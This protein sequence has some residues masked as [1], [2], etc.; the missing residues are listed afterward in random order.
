ME[1]GTGL[2]MGG[3]LALSTLWW[4]LTRRSA[5]LP[6]GPGPALPLIGHLHLLSKDP[7]QQFASWRRRYGD[8]FSLYVGSQLV[9]VLNGYKVIKDALVKHADVFSDR[10]HIYL[11]DYISK[12]KG[13]V[14]SSG[15]LW[16]EQRKVSLEILREM[17]MGKNVLAEKIHEEVREYVKAVAAHQGKS[18]DPKDM[19]HVSVSNNICSVVFGTRYAYDDPTFLNYISTMDEN[20]KL[21]NKATALDFVPLLKYLPGDMFNTKV[22]MKNVNYIQDTFLKPHLKS[23]SKNFSRGTDQV[24]DFTEGYLREMNKVNGKSTTLD[25]ENLMMVMGD[26]F[27]A[28]TESTATAIRWALVYFL[29]Y[30]EV[31]EKCFQEIQRVIGAGRAPTIRDRPELTYVEA[32]I[33]EVLRL[34]DIAPFSVQHGL[35][36][37]VEFMGYKLPKGTVIIPNLESVLHDPDIWDEPLAFRPERFLDA[38]GKL[39]K[40]EEFIPFSMGRRVCLGKAMARTE[41]FL[42]LTAMIQ[43][44]RF[45]PPETGELPSLKGIFGMAISPNCYKVRAVSR[46]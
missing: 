43:R 10:P 27:V 26:L 44:F 3:V 32:T 34:A 38:S 39:I 5:G 6:P 29:H 25:E 41:L 46:D 45:L 19:T 31:Q 42:Y 24:S 1:P 16:K 13:V 22:I 15:V 17:G 9:V 33:M 36:E 20:F 30:P 35:E 37:D 7:R 40:P 8:V 23:H 11:T 21:I 2:L 28:G 14:A 18:F 4:W 12:N